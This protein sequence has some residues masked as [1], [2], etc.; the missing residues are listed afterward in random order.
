MK[1]ALT[2]A[3]SDSGGGA[4][5]QADL[6]TF[7]AH[8]V[9]GA[10][11]V[12]AITAQNTREV[13][14]VQELPPAIIC[15]QLAAVLDDLDIAAAKTG[16]LSSATIIETVAGE[17]SRRGFQD[18]VVDPVMIAKSGYR[19]LAED[20]VA[21]LRGTLLPLARVVT[22][23]LHEAR[24]L[25]GLDIAS[26]DDMKRAAEK[27]A[28]MG[29]RAVVVKGG[30]ATFALA[31]D[32]LWTERGMVELKPEGPV[33]ERS[34]HGTGCTFSAAITARLALGEALP[35]AVANAKRYITRTIRHA[36][37]IGHGHPPAAHFYFLGS[38]DWDSETET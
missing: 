3:G 7:H 4:G 17:L 37:A 16:M 33:R 26:L 11:V 20:A 23:N 1:Q 15:A 25:S 12:T 30:H 35:T 38:G 19:L 36:P 29:P 24:L 9:F 2:I 22:P 28:A 5:I 6:K 13:R 8:G 32:V 10:S 34:I 31:V 14:E 27:I 21:A 18:L